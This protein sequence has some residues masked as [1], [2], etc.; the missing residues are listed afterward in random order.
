MVHLPVDGARTPV[1]HPFPVEISPKDRFVTVYG[2]KPVLEALD[3]PALSVDKVVL[4][5][6]AGAAGD[7]SAGEGAGGQRQAGPGRAR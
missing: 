6:C 1:W 4:A 5:W 7:G 3:D 2:R